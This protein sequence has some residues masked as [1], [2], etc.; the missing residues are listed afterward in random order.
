MDHQAEGGVTP[1]R[2]PT[3]LSRGF[4]G[5]PVVQFSIRR[6]WLLQEQ[7]C[8][9]LLEGGRILSP[10][11]GRAGEKSIHQPRETPLTLK[12]SPLASACVV[13]IF[14]ILIYGGQE[15]VPVTPLSHRNAR[16]G[17]KAAATGYDPSQGA[18][19]GGKHRQQSK[20]ACP[21]GI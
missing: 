5:G 8:W 2:V 15:A 3:G 14:T 9:D 11:T 16:T 21:P 19:G 10:L 1:E 6:L 7:A 4:L 13:V 20:Q 12:R 17:L 18:D